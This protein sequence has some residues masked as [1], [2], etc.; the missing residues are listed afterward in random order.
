MTLKGKHPSEETRRKM[1]ES[2]NQLQPN[3]AEFRTAVL[4]FSRFRQGL[5]IS[6]NE[7]RKWILMH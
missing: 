3:D 7:R 2:I 6:F 5:A 4:K 1:S